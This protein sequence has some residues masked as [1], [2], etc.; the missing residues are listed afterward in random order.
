ML[1]WIIAGLLFSAA[2]ITICVAFLSSDVAKDKAKAECP[3]AVK[4]AIKSVVKNGN[5]NVVKMD[6]LDDD[7]DKISEISFE[8]DEISSDI[9]TG[10]KIYI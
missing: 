9:Y 4:L 7:D 2:V 8:A 6:A 5:V 3:N 10:K 1:G